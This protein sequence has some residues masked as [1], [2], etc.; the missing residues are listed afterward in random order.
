M[1]EA[2]ENLENERPDDIEVGQKSRES[3]APP[4]PSNPSVRKIT[5]Q[6]NL[7]SLSGPK[8]SGS[9]TATPSWV[10]D[11]QSSKDQGMLFHIMYT[12]QLLIFI[13]INSNHRKIQYRKN[14][15]RM[16]AKEGWEKGTECPSSEKYGVRA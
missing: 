1:N 6:Y 11:Y 16:G 5:P 2:A 12:K 15:N 7:N 8:A 10:E 4:P 14:V 3:T 9:G 13:C